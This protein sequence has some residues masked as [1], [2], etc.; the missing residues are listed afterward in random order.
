[1]VWD[2]VGGVRVRGPG[3]E[4][5]ER[6]QGIPELPNARWEEAP[7]SPALPMPAWPFGA[8]SGGGA[9]LSPTAAGRSALGSG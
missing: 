7:G 1:M 2:R 9:I 8:G 4:G 5:R 3:L 6:R